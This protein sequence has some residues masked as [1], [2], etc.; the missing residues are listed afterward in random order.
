MRPALSVGIALCAF[1]AMALVIAS[2]L[3]CSSSEE[4]DETP[5][6]ALKQFLEAMERYDRERAFKLLAPDVQ[7]ELTKRAK[8]ASKQAGRKLEP[9]QMLVVERSVNRWD[10][11]EMEPTI[12]EN[13]AV[14]KVQGAQKSQ[15]AEVELEL[16]DGHWRVI[17]PL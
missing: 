4:T 17:V 8:T 16:I 15:T 14:V 11:K 10:I 2:Q 13:R 6:G 12:R 1:A 7:Q 3:G 5:N 9:H